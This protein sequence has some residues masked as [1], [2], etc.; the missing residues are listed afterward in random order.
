VQQQWDSDK[1][2]LLIFERPGLLAAAQF[3][4]EQPGTD[5]TKTSVRWTELE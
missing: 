4:C 5:R 3:P 2:N 1:R